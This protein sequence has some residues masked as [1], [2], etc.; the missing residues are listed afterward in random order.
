M[1]AKYF[2]FYFH[3]L[4]IVSEIERNIDIH[5]AIVYMALNYH[6]LIQEDIRHLHLLAAKNNS[7]PLYGQTLFV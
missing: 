4:S 2:Y 3:V 5:T 7:S 6:I 1:I